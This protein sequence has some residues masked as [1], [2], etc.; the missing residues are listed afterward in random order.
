MWALS[1]PVRFRIWELLRS[2]PATAS[3][4]A[5][6]LGESRG[7]MSYHLRMLA[8]TGVIVEDEE[9]GTKRE[10]WWRRPEEAVPITPGSDTE[11]GSN[12]QTQLQRTKT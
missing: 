3:H 1:H 7:S 2:G 6:K 11:S 8:S 4:L 9:L 12:R 10:R 5:R